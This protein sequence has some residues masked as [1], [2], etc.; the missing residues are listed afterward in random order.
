[1]SATGVELELREVINEA[2]TNISVLKETVELLIYY[3]LSSMVAEDLAFEGTPS[4]DRIILYDSVI[5]LNQ[6]LGIDSNYN[7]DLLFK[8]KHAVV[9]S[10]YSKFS[11][12]IYFDDEPSS[13]VYEKVIEPFRNIQNSI[14][15]KFDTAPLLKLEVS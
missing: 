9:F 15:A 12:I 5:K 13:F 10:F 14:G 2:T 8:S 4:E 11:E 7:K 1:M 6:P 3:N